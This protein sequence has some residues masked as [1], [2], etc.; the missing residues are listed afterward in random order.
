MSRFGRFG[1]SFRFGQES[2]ARR[3]PIELKRPHRVPGTRSSA[4]D[5]DIANVSADSSGHPLPRRGVPCLERGGLLL[6]GEGRVNGWA[7][8]EFLVHGVRNAFRPSWV[9]RLEASRR[10][11][12]RFRVSRSQK[13]APSS[14]PSRLRI[15]H[16]L[17]VTYVTSVPS[18][19]SQW[20]RRARSRSVKF[21]SRNHSTKRRMPTIR[22][23]V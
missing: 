12:Q 17:P 22:I 5:A 20:R 23:V 3:D 14:E 2:P 8:L 9:P 10:Q 6:P 16:Q 4:A 15:G 1:L 7:I 13:T 19:C 21:T 11:A 18:M